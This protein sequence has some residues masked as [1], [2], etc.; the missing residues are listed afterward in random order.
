MLLEYVVAHSLYVQYC[1]QV[2]V[3]NQSVLQ[4]TVIN[5]NEQ[6]FVHKFPSTMTWYYIF[7]TV[8]GK[9]CQIKEELNGD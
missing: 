2:T 8:A 5:P 4:N 9:Q 7:I 6:S 3:M 1:L